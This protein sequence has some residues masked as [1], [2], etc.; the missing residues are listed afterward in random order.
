MK[1][2]APKFSRDV[3]VPQHMNSSSFAKS[4]HVN[5]QKM[6]YLSVS[7]YHWHD[8]PQIWYTVSGSYYHTING[9]RKKQTPGSVA[10]VFPFSVHSID[11][12]Q[13]N[14][15]E[16]EVFSISFFEDL[17]N[18]GDV[19]FSPIDYKT[20]AYDN[21][22]LPQFLHLDGQ[23]KEDGDILSRALFSE[24][25]KHF[26]MNTVKIISLLNS[27]LELCAK[28]ANMPLTTNLTSSD[29]E[30]NF[31]LFNSIA[32]MVQNHQKNLTLDDLAHHSMMSKRSF[33][34]KFKAMTGITCHNYF[35]S[36]KAYYA[37]QNYWFSLSKISEIA[38]EYG[39]ASG[40]HF[41][42]SVTTQYKKSPYSLKKDLINWA[43]S[44]GEF[45]FKYDNERYY[46]TGIWSEDELFD[47]KRFAC[48]HF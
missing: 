31:H 10:F 9:V 8:Y 22:L 24:F 39:F 4:F 14:I 46:W 38:E 30:Q 3:I 1:V 43:C 25:T 29:M 6:E 7:D 40:T 19:G 2:I 27:F 34:E 17:I 23:A 32:F 20:A 5:I 37:M 12:S 36:V 11:S 15:D 21:F 26:E 28:T 47:L 45:L 41:I 48:G 16:V 35:K 44:Y 18:S 13:T 33:T 42:T